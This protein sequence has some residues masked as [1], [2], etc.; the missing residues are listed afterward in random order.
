M[1]TSDRSSLGNPSPSTGTGATTTD[2]SGNL[3]SSN[4]PSTNPSASTTSK[5][6][7]DIKGAAQGVVGGAQAALGTT[8][9]NQ[10]MANE[11]F[12]KM[13]NEDQRLGAKHGVPSVGADTR[14]TTTDSGTA[15]GVPGIGGQTQ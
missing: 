9:R 12:E 7:G 11:G 3:I 8:I 14:N 4:D 5:L 13:S 1:S 15:G 10:K 6:T 2:T